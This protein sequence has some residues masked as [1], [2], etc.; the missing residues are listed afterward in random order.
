M[1]EKKEIKICKIGSPTM[2]TERKVYP[3]YVDSGEKIDGE[4]V[5]SI[6]LKVVETKVDIQEYINSFADDC[7]VENVLRKFA[8]TGDASL[9]AV[10]QPIENVDATKMP[11]KSAE[12]LFADLPADL[13]KDMTFE[14]FVKSLTQEQLQAYIDGLVADSIAAQTKKEEVSNNE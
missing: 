2:V 3:I 7:G 13:R 10:H 4:P 1:S 12:E 5:G 8:R 9:F 6:T 14:Q 11:E